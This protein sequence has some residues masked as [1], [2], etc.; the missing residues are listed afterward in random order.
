MGVQTLCAGIN[1]SNVILEKKKEHYEANKDEI[2]RKKKEREQN[3]DADKSSNWTDKE[4][5]LLLSDRKFPFLC[6]CRKIIK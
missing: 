1:R 3:I 5:K 6:V 4:T 2:L